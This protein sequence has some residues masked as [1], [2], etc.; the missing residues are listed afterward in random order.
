MNKDI[1]EIAEQVRQMNLRLDS[2]INFQIK[3]AE[4][5]HLV[6]NKIHE[7]LGAIYDQRV[8]PVD[9]S[10]LSEMIES[11]LESTYDKME[12]VRAILDDP[13]PFNLKELEDHVLAA[14]VTLDEIRDSVAPKSEQD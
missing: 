7:T 5:T 12:E 11:K 13:S 4:A 3:S 9:F 1:K 6:L 14:S 10:E 2:L 8:E